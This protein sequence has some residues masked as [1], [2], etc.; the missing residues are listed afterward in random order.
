MAA[1]KSY[2]AGVCCAVVSVIGVCVIDVGVG[3]DVVGKIWTS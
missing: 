2:W 1:E 3:C